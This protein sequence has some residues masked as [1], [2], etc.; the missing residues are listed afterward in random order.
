[1]TSISN[2]PLTPREKQIVDCLSRGLR[3]K[4]I[5][6]DL[7]LSIGTVRVYISRMQD[8]YG[9]RYNRYSFVLLKARDYQRCRAIELNEWIERWRET[10]QP[11]ALAEIQSIMCR[12]VAEFLKEI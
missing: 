4:E 8:K 6:N 11:Q 12:Q 9:A 3:N 5:A 2:K 10:L 1:M 7:G